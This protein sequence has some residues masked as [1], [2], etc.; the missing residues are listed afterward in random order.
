MRY[1]LVFF[2][3]TLLPQQAAQIIRQLPRYYLPRLPRKLPGVPIQLRG[4]TYQLDAAGF[5]SGTLQRIINCYTN[6][7]VEGIFGPGQIQATA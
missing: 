4:I 6:E 2:E 7:G 1:N 3:K 5:Q